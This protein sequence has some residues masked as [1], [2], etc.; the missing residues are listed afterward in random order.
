MNRGLSIPSLCRKLTEYGSFLIFTH[1]SPD[2]DTLGSA[3]A[4]KRLLDVAGK[5]TEVVCADPVPARL[6]FI[7]GTDDLSMERLHSFIPDC[8]LTVDVADSKLLGRYEHMAEKIDVCIDHHIK[9]SMLGKYMHVQ[10]DASSCGEII[11]LIGKQ[12]E[13]MKVSRT[14]G[15]F[16][17]AVY[18]AISSDTGG[19]IYSNVTAKTHRIAAD[20]HNYDI[21]FA[22][23]NERL[24]TLTS[25]Q[26]L[27]LKADLISNMVYYADGKIAGVCIDAEKQKRFG[28]ENGQLGDV[29]NI[30]RSVDG[31]L[32]AF[33]AKES[34]EGNYKVSIRTKNADASA[35]AARFGGGG[36]VKAAGCTVNAPDIASCADAVAAVCKEALGNV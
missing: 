13:K 21:D 16:A 36:H 10:S 19:F 27:A 24:H 29:V 20:L 6:R 18:A 4:L 32:I 12:L 34:E 26:Q 25:R 3:F 33:S 11:Y 14:D 1:I 35:I 30:P 2:G 7:T 22:E 15:I 9:R 23:I 8:I 5:R 17:S 28:L 31:V